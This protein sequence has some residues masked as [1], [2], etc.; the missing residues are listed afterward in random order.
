MKP[1]KYRMCEYRIMELV[2]FNLATIALIK[3]PK[4]DRKVTF[5]RD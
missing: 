1:S 4:S 2:Q 3:P 5:L